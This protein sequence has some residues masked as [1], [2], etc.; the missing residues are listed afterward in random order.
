MTR[1]QLEQL[2]KGELIEIILQLQ[3]RVAELEEELGRLIG[4][5]K[6]WIN[7]SIPPAKS[8]RANRRKSEGK[9]G[10]KRGHQGHG[11]KPQQPEV[12]IEC[13][14]HRC[15]RCGADLTRYP[16]QA[17]TYQSGR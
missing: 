6:D 16:R 14:P 12:P 1:K 5:P 15:G 3:Q 8:P 10:P 17:D 11:G 4:L 7:S 9:R 2:S 13:R